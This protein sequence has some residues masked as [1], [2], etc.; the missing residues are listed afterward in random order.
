MSSVWVVVLAGCVP[1][2]VEPEV[3]RVPIDT[4]PSRQYTLAEAK[5][6]LWRP[7]LRPPYRNPTPAEVDAVEVLIP[8]LLRAAGAGVI[9]PGAVARASS[10]GLRVE[11]WEIAG[12]SPQLVLSEEPDQRRGAGAYLFSTAHPAAGPHWWLLEAPHAYHDKNTGAIGLQL[13]LSPPP[14]A[15]PSAFFTNSVHR[16]TQ[17]DGRRTKRDYNPADA[18]HARGH[19]LNVA[20]QAAARAASGAVV[21]QIHG[22]DGDEEDLDG[23]VRPPPDTLAVVSGGE[24]DAPTPFAAAAAGALRSVFGEGIR[25]FPTEASA[26]GATTNVEMQGLRDAPRATFLHVEASD[27]L[28]DLLVQDAG[29]RDA[30]GAAL[31]ALD[32]EHP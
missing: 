21:V 13:Y 12:T 32:P 7:E 26:L 19:L 31:F 1:H 8:E 17:T 2:G 9:D 3:V 20:T 10:V 23:G 30:F 11:R 29:R 16:Y 6:H 28:R 24:A 27:R 22:F 4:L 14:G 18:C 15:T 25:L 5:E